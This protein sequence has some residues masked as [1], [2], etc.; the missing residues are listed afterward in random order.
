VTG[1]DHDT[2]AL[3]AALR[4][5]ALPSE[6]VGEDAA[7]A[8]MLD[9]LSASSAQP[10]VHRSRRG[11]AIAAVTVASLGVGGLV[12]AGP[13]HFFFPAAD[14]SP[15]NGPESTAESSTAASST[16]LAE[17]QSP[18][19]MLPQLATTSTLVARIA[20][21]GT[22]LVRGP[23]DPETELESEDCDADNH[24]G[25]VADVAR[26]TV[27]GQDVRDVA[28]SDCGKPDE[29]GGSDENPS[30]TAPGQTGESP[31]D[32]APGRTGETPATTAPGQTGETP[33]T[34]APGQTGETPAPTPPGQTGET[35]APTP[36]GQTGETP[37]PTPPGQTGENGRP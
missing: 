23:E 16:S 14:R 22:D 27:P 10:T 15:A 35:P 30:D 11:I 33:A 4:S 26:S 6:Q 8:A 37:A 5:P 36:P 19:T 7:V 17:D 12:A 25:A 24:G 29:A 13:G 32:T 28:R 3:I 20:E 2:D 9:A 34:T 21:P 31:S 18:G 1:E